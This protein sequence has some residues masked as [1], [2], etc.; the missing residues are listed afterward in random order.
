[1]CTGAKTREV[2]KEA[3]EKLYH[4]VR[5]VGIAKE[6]GEEE[7]FEEEDEEMNFL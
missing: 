4:E 3:V 1:M 6:P 5:N 2:V 7:D